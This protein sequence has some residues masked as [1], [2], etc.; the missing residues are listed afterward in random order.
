[1]N[2]SF[3]PQFLRDPLTNLEADDITLKFNDEFKPVVVL[4]DEGFLCV[5]MPMRN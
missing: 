3:N 5:I 1:V 2:I 4:G